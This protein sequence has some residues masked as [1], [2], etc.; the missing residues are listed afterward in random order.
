ML[1]MADARTLAFQGTSADMHIAGSKNKKCT[2]AKSI[3]LPKKEETCVICVQALNGI[4]KQI[5]V[6]AR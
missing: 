5:K 3:K 4:S 1:T 6:T 2:N